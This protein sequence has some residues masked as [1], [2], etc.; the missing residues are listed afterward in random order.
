MIWSQKHTCFNDLST[1]KLIY[2]YNQ[3][4]SKEDYITDMILSD[5]YKYFITSTQFGHIYVWKLSK[6][7]GNKIHSFVG[8]TKTVTSLSL[9][10]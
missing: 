3:L 10:P 5:E 7:K 9:H 2:R 1:G 8:H 6:K 4:T